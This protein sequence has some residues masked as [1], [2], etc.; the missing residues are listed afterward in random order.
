MYQAIHKCRLCGEVI[1]SEILVQPNVAHRIIGN[2]VYGNQEELRSEPHPVNEY[3]AHY[4]KDGS[5]GLC[6]FQGFKKIG[7]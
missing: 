1:E 7:E 6:D 3:D 2:F 4:C 5:F